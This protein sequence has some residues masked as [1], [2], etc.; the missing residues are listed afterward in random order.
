[1]FVPGYW[2]NQARSASRLGLFQ[3]LEIFPMTATIPGGSN[4]YIPSH[5]A[6]GKLVVDFSRNPS[7]FALAKY[8]QIVPVTEQLGYYLEMTVEEAARVLDDDGF[9]VDWPDGNY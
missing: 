9:D 2:N 4:A 8:A 3:H 7:K 1:S 5:E 6:S